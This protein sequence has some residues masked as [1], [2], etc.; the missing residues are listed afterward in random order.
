MDGASRAPVEN[1]FKE[2][3]ADA[4]TH[5]TSFGNND[6]LAK[7]AS[8]QIRE[9]AEEMVDSVGRGVAFNKSKD[10]LYVRF[11]EILQGPVA[12]MI[13]DLGAPPRMGILVGWW[14]K[15]VWRGRSAVGGKHFKTLFRGESA[16]LMC[17][18]RTHSK[19][20][21][22]AHPLLSQHPARSQQCFLMTPSFGQVE[23]SA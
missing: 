17:I 21:R 8:C 2:F 3:L 13:K 9:I 4:S 14:P 16:L 12:L 1:D 19:R 7:D 23:S 11:L 18:P 15:H 6:F 5:K 22:H 20:T 10:E